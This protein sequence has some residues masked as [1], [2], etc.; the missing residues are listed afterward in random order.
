MLGSDIFSTPIAK[1]IGILLA[2]IIIAHT[3]AEEKEIA[4]GIKINDLIHG[5]HQKYL[6]RVVLRI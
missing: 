4:K 5:A 1:A 6:E 3:R 2:Y